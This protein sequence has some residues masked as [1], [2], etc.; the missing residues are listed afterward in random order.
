MT[1][2][3]VTVGIAIAVCCVAGA[4]I[5]SGH[6]GAGSRSP[7]ALGVEKLLDS[8]PTATDTPVKFFSLAGAPTTP[9]GYGRSSFGVI[10][11]S[12]KWHYQYHDSPNSG[13]SEWGSLTEDF[14]LCGLGDV[15]PHKQNPM[16]I[17]P[18]ETTP[19]NKLTPLRWSGFEAPPFD[20]NSTIEARAFF[21][22][23]TLCLQGPLS[24][25]GKLG[26]PHLPV[27]GFS[28]YLPDLQLDVVPVINFTL[29]EIRFHTP[30]EHSIGRRYTW[31]Y[32]IRI[33]IRVHWHGELLTRC[34]FCALSLLSCARARAL[35]RR[36]DVSLRDAD[37]TRMQRRD[38][39]TM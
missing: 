6:A 8:I 28:R 33:I 27:H 25:H 18:T 34:L 39:A 20:K 38:G 23:H 2:Q 26:N 11:P 12:T 13:P 31:L 22:G 35:Y 9:W 10:S 7:L 19:L 30:A 21:D 16:N 3:V 29:K 32:V 4:A 36:S 14:A 17:L 37:D 5:G 24:A 15:E 1:W